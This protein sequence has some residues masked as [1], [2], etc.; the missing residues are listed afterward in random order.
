MNNFHWTNIISLNN[1]Q[2]IAFEE[3]VCQLAEQEYLDSKNKFIKVG[4]PDGGC[5]CYIQ[6]EN[7]HEIGFQAKFFRSTPQETQWNQI[8]ESLKTA[9]KKHP[10]LTTYYIAIPLDRADPRIDNQHWFMD[11]WNNKTEGWKKYI[12]ATYNKDFKFVYWGSY[13]LIA[14]LSKDDNTG[15]KCFFFGEIGLSDEWLLDNNKSAIDDLGARYTPEVNVEVDVAKYFDALSRN[16]RFKNKL[17]S[18]YHELMVSYREFISHMYQKI[19][20]IESN[21]SQ[22]AVKINEL[23]TLYGQVQFDGIDYINNDEIGTLLEKLKQL[24]YDI[25]NSLFE[26][27]QKEL[28]AKK[29]KSYKGYREST[30]YDNVIRDFHDFNSNLHKFKELITSNLVKLANNPFLILN[31]EAGTGKSHLLADIVNERSNEGFSSLFLLG[32]HFREDKDPWSQILGL[33]QLRCDKS[34]LLGTLN[35]KAKTQGKRLIIFIDA[36]NE[37]RGRAFWS[38]FIISFIK[39]IKKY[40]WLG[41]VM[42]IRSSY[43]DLMIPQQLLTDNLALKI[44]HRGFEGIEYDAAKLFFRYYN[45]LQPA[46]PLLHP[47]FSN[48]LFLKLFCEGLSYKG[49]TYI[50]DGYEGISTIIKF[51]IEGIEEKLKQ[52][53][54]NIVTLK[55]I[56]KTIDAFIPKMLGNQTITYDDALSLFVE[57]IVNKYGIDSEF[58]EDLV[59][60][61]LFIHNVFYNY[62][63][64]E[65]KEGL[66]F[67][68][69]RFEDHLKVKYIFDNHLHKD[70]PKTSFGQAPICSYF[71][72]NEVY[73]NRGIIEAMCIQLP[74]IC[75]TEVIDVVNQNEVIIDGFLNSLIWRKVES[76]SPNVV[77]R[78]IKNISQKPFQTII[79]KILF[80]NATNPK[81]PLNADLLFKYLSEF[82]MRDR[83]VLLIPILNEIYLQY[84]INPIERLIDWSWSDE[85]KSHISDESILLTAITL[86]WLLISSNRELR[87]YSTKALISILRKRNSVVL[88]LLK[89]FENI[90]EPYIYERLFAVTFGVVVRAENQTDLKE[91][92]EYIYETIFNKDEVFPHILLRD[93]AKNTID[94]II[95]VGIQLDIEYSKI[96]PPYMSFF[97]ERKDLPSNDEIEKYKDRENGYHQSS[98]ISS[99]R[100][101]FGGGLY[102]DFGRYVF[103]SAL[104]NFDCKEYEQLLSNYA[105]KKIFS[106]YGYC[107]ELFKDAEDEIRKIN[108]DYDRHKHRVERIGKKYQWIAFYDILARVCDNCKMKDRTAWYREEKYTQYKGS[109]EPYVR[110]IDPTILL[111]PADK[112]V[113]VPQRLWWDPDVDVKYKMDNYEWVK[114]DQDL[115]NPRKILEVSDVNNEKW[116]ALTSYP[117]W[118]EPLPKGY[119]K[120][121]TTHK[122]LWYQLRSYLIPK[123]DLNEFKNWADHQNFWGS[124][125]PYSE[126]NYQVFKR[127]FYWSEAYSFF[128][129]HYYGG[130]EQWTEINENR[131]GKKYPNKVALTTEEYFWEEQYDYSKEG[132]WRI[133]VPSKLL[134]EGLNLHYSKREGELIDENGNMV[135][136]DP[137]IFHKTWQTLL[138]KKEDLIKYLNNNDMTVVWTVVGEK[139]VSTPG[140]NTEDFHGLMEISGFT[141]LLEEK[142]FNGDLKIRILDDQRKEVNKAI[143]MN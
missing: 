92:G 104:Y 141:F 95:S 75:N 57:K 72:E 78:L 81:H 94:Y 9:L 20:Q 19:E 16:E 68:Y 37:G 8:E 38:G 85:D 125:M 121:D 23:E 140:Y 123:K 62:Q 122:E 13:E 4:N 124:W 91:F 40:E 46:I 29:I 107:G 42:S 5:E 59:R 2:N 83:D 82:E 77:E 131:Y 11:K 128:K 10:N 39:S 118:E 48:P 7:D 70:N 66:Y 102:G 136:F 63:S 120:F 12:K 15:L 67:A 109:F 56:N 89:K 110:D 61:G 80:T 114:F 69:E 22:L 133:L 143:K 24:S 84:D 32:Q 119:D 18:S 43:F 86:S 54:P 127:E 49:L 76:I 35:T 134:F 88:Q 117:E 6:L 96:I 106:E 98:I 138:I 44:T 33:L 142:L 101:E 14:R 87:D 60:E 108:R 25:S 50:P 34:K 105:T 64:K 73:F 99:M 129:N 90:H 26:L 53:Y 139:R 30:Q 93:Y 1:S 137:S 51:F 31:G 112:K 113:G 74:E 36:I 103:G 79:F 116:I 126:G 17:D 21:L 27:N 65:H 130:Y 41:L 52:K 47:E 100:T 115:P 28:E 111:K 71:D 132:A 58:L 135:L 97:P 45:I 3:L 55:L